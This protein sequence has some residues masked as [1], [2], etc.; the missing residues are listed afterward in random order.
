LCRDLWR[1]SDGK[2]IDFVIKKSFGN[3]AAFE[4]KTQCKTQKTKALKTFENT[5]PDYPLQ[6][7]SLDIN[8]GCLWVLKL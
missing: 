3:G 6:T 7:I 2:E 4:V 8:P 5:Y 1:T